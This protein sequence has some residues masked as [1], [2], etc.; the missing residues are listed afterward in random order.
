MK[1]ISL[2]FC[3][4]LEVSFSLA[5]QSPFYLVLTNGQQINYLNY[6]IKGKKVVVKQTGYR[7]KKEVWLSR[8]VG[9]YSRDENIMHY[10]LPDNRSF[11]P[12][13]A[14]G[15]IVLY[16]KT[17][18]GDLT[19]DAFGQLSRKPTVNLYVLKNGKSQ[20]VFDGRAFRKKSNL[21]TLK[22]LF[23]GQPEVINMINT[24]GNINQKT[25]VEAVNRYNYLSHKPPVLPEN[26]SQGAIVFY[27]DRKKKKTKISM[28]IGHDKVIDLPAKSYQTIRVPAK[29]FTAICLKTETME[30][31]STYKATPH[32]TK[33]YKVTVNKEGEIDRIFNISK[34]I[35][36][37]DIAQINK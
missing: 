9:Y 13:L 10:K 4:M 30:R 17:E 34:K 25:V 6:N 12:R 35:A 32:F 5:Q 23:A 36:R 24:A 20:K 28:H 11:L 31:C 14:D 26:Y 19:S 7:G 2:L 15:K 16:A 22:V 33:Y 3:L 18:L 29:Y 8:V 27:R 1:P 21:S 37:Y